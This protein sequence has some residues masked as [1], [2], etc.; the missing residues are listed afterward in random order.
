MKITNFENGC[1]LY[2]LESSKLKIKVTDAGASL[3]S[4]IYPDKNGN[5]TDIVLGFDN[6]DGYLNKSTYFGANVGRYANR[7][8]KATFTLNNKVYQLDKNDGENCL[9]SGFKCLC[10]RIYDVVSYDNNHITFKHVSPHLDQGFPGELTMLIT[11]KLNDNSSFEVYYEATPSEDTPIVM[12]NHSYF[13]L[14]GEGSGTILNHIV[15]LNA[16]HF[17]PTDEHLI[18]D[19]TILEV[20]DTPM[21]FTVAHKVG[22]HINDEYTP[23]I[24][25]GG[26]DHNFIASFNDNE[27]MTIVEAEGDVSGIKMKIATDYPGFQVYSGNFL[28]GELGK[29][30]HV[31]Q[32]REAICF[33]PQ[34]FP[35]AINLPNFISPICKKG[36]T[37]RKKIAYQFS[38]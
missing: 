34:Y 30:G 8:G 37:Y 18:C 20:K 17:T 15:K 13:N 14:N 5:D 38:N 9:H 27:F 16:T 24:N 2:T 26:Y 22:D 29:K 11:Y 28:N 25:C 7:I 1:S 35:N 36:E 31:Y 32:K 33:E 4:I 12:T 6:S 3:V 21:D 10:N 23:L 19:G